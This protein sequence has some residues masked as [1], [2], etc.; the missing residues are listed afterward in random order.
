MDALLLKECARCPHGRTIGGDGFCIADG[1]ACRVPIQTRIAQ[2]LCPIGKFKL[3]AGD[4]IAA[5]MEAVGVRLPIKRAI[6]RVTGK[7]CE[8]P[9]RQAALNAILPSA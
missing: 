2:R 6:E 9:K 8:C 5:G 4:A 1:R 7:P 3:G